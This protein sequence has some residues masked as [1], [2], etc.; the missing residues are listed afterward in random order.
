MKTAEQTAATFIPNTTVVLPSQADLL[1]MHPQSTFYKIL[2][3]HE[4]ANQW[5]RDAIAS[6]TG[7]R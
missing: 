4:E 3:A 6:R 2:A 5:N 7:A 1:Q